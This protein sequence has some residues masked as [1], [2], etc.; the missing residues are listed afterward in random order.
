MQPLGP[1]I[2]MPAME[3]HLS[4]ITSLF[5]QT[6][7]RVSIQHYTPEQ[8]KIWASGA[9]DTERWLNRI[10]EQ[11]F[12]VALINGRIT[13]FASMDYVTGYLDTLFVHHSWQGHGI[14]T[15]LLEDIIAFAR[16]WGLK[17]ITTEASITARPLFEKNGFVVTEAQDKLHKGLIFR[18]YKMVLQL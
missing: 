16:R 4:D 11:Y 13:G 5:R 1:T 7:K 14:G 12:I 9:D 10:Q 3:T 15:E 8:V 2:I 17:E 6:I 18:N